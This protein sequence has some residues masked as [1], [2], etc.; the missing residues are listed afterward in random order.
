MLRDARIRPLAVS[1][2]TLAGG[3]IAER[4][5][6]HDEIMIAGGCIGGPLAVRSRHTGGAF[7]V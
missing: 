2:A 1:N 5:G 6:F 7:A 3:I 4:A